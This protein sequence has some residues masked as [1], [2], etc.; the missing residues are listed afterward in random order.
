[1]SMKGAFRLPELPRFTMGPDAYMGLADILRPLGGP[2]LVYAGKRALTAG[3]GALGGAV[4]GLGIILVKMIH[5]GECTRQRAHE[6]ARNAALLKAKAVIGMG[7]GRAIDVAKAAAFFAGL[8]CVTLP[9]IPATCAAVSALC[10]MH[11]PGQDPKDALLFLPSP[12]LHAFLHTGICAASPAMYLRAGIGDS[13][14]K[15]VE[16]AWK[17]WCG[18]LTYADRLGLSIARLGYD[19]LLEVGEEALSDA[20]AGRDTEAYRLAAQCCV[21]NTGLVSFDEILEEIK[22]HSL[23]YALMGVKEIDRYLHGEIVAW[24]SI[25]Q[26]LIAG[27]K[28]KALELAAFLDAI[29][30]PSTLRAMGVSMNDPKLRALLAFTLSQPDMAVTPCAV[31]EGMLMEA[32]EGAENLRSGV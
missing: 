32:V 19:T 26:L 7:G 21:L 9:T 8:P 30:I 17:A 1:M 15:R 11:D 13:V 14:A 20:Q 22:S 10:V 16:S 28:E 18:G 31:T 4:S 5:E 24:A 2:V 25:P 23:Y 6:V 27:E 12:P 29:G 3:L